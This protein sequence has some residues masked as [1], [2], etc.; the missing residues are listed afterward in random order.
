MIMIYWMSCVIARAFAKMHCY[1][2]T[3]ASNTAGLRLWSSLVLSSLVVLMPATCV[4][5]YFHGTSINFTLNY[6]CLRTT[7]ISSEIII[8][9]ACYRPLKRR[10][11][12]MNDRSFSTIFTPMQLSVRLMPALHIDNLTALL[13]DDTAESLCAPS[14]EVH[15]ANASLRN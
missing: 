8:R 3:H 9:F 7:P 11:I 2:P 6:S 1:C 4:I 15:I 5:C 12:P 10:A 14:S 13:I